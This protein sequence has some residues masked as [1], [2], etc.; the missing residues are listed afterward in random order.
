MTDHKYEIDVLR[1]RG[2][3]HS[4]LAADLLELHDKTGISL[5]EWN[6]ARTF[7]E[8]EVRMAVRSKAGD[9]FKVHP[10]GV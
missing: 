7:V 6:S 9:M 1:S 5:D 10:N 4:T 2:G 3:L 8:C